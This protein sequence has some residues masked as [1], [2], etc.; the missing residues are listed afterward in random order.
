MAELSDPV[1]KALEDANFWHLATLN[2]DGSPQSTPV[3]VGLR[4]R[5]IL[6]NSH[7]GRKKQRNLDHDPRVALSVVYDPE[8]P[9][10]N[11]GIQG[12]VVERIVGPQAASDIQELADKYTGNEYPLQEGEERVTYLIEPTHVWH[13]V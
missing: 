4:D 1:R 12:R 7:L 3:W 8:S 2:P 6:V 13:R 9:Y 5:K 10:S 11:I